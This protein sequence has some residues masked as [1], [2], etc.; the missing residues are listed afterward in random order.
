MPKKQLF[1]LEQTLAGVRS[2]AGMIDRHF[3]SN[4]KD[5]AIVGIHQMGVPLAKLICS[6]LE[7]LGRTPEFGQLDITMYRDDIGSRSLLPR[8]HETVIPFDVNDKEIILVDDV[9]SSG[10]TIRAA[11]D[12]LTD[13]GRPGLIR[14]AVLVDR[15]EPEFPIRADFVGF[16]VSLPSD[17]K[18]VVQFDHEDD[19]PA[20]I[21]EKIWDRN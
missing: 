2:V 17:R 6:E 20:G 4:G 18:V 11:L 10:R 16:N 5:F 1:D 14:L 21:Y 7:K 8:I 9:L 3:A 13:Y 15:G 12:A 19:M